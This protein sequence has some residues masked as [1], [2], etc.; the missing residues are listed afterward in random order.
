MALISYPGILLLNVTDSSPAQLAGL[1]SGMILTEVNN[2][3][4]IPTYT[5]YLSGTSYLLDEIGDVKP[6]QTIFVKA[7]ETIYS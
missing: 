1:E 5:E 4:I 6:N 3:Q 7:N 2:K